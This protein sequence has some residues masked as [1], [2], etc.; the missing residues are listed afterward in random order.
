MHVSARLSV[1]RPVLMLG[2]ACLVLYPLAAVAQ[3]EPES[4]LPA[5]L[6]EGRSTAFLGVVSRPTAS[7][8]VISSVVPDSSAWKLGLEAGDIIE[9][10]DGY[11][12]GIVNGA[13]YSLP[14][15]IRRAG[16]EVEL[17]IRD[18]RTGQTITRTAK[19][20]GRAVNR[21][22]AGNTPKLGVNTQVGARGETIL[23]ITPGSAAEK[24]RLKVGDLITSV[25]GYR[26]GI[27]EGNVY[28][29][30]SEIRHAGSECL[31][32][33]VRNGKAENFYA[34]FGPH[35]RKTSRVNVLLIG[36]TD[37]ASIGAGIKANLE[38][39]AGLLEDIPKENRGKLKIITGAECT[40]KVILEQVQAL[41]VAPDE[42]LF[43]YYAGHGAYNPK[44][45]DA[46][47]TSKG[48]FFQIPGGDL[49]RM[50]LMTELRG[51]GGRLTVLITDTCNVPA[52][53][54]EF[55]MAPMARETPEPPIVGLLLRCAGVVDISGASRNQFGWYLGKGGIFTIAF[56]TSVAGGAS[57]WSGLL[58]QAREMTHVYYREL[59]EAVRKE[60]NSV[61]ADI[62]KSLE[63]QKDQSPQAFQLD[64]RLD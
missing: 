20:G 60:P 22:A 4:P 12:I 5:F 18:T 57:T 23:Q 36:L 40:A 14:S 6:P 1:L 54:H 28:S 11:K 62:R 37:D 41:T 24:A 56:T 30:A 10:I 21:G 45:A 48:H 3:P 7:G 17:A 61:S 31:L 15:E 46:G 50:K 27:M 26:V 34:Q 42:A 8:A 43:C 55:Q 38:S 13:T 33:V 44:A 58:S 16:E 39:I 59:K 51:K 2:L 19:V 64:V 9:S 25:D 52:I 63:G 49:T 53:P 47:D 29:L 35:A 32:S